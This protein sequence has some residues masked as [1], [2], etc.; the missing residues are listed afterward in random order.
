M[1][2]RVFGDQ[3]S[4]ASGDAN[5]RTGSRLCKNVEWRSPMMCRYGRPY[6]LMFW[7]APDPDAAITDHIRKL[8]CER[9]LN[10]SRMQ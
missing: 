9:W 4:T 8:E 7:G 2:R 5:V 6:G 1:R 10:Y 3:C